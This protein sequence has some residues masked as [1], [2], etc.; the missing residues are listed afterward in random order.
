MSSVKRS[1]EIVGW[2]VL[3]RL[4]LPGVAAEAANCVL[5]QHIM[6]DGAHGCPPLRM[7]GLAGTEAT[8]AL[9]LGDCCGLGGVPTEVS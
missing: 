7:P 2:A 5:A 1:L 6:P 3:A 8:R 4:S 9:V